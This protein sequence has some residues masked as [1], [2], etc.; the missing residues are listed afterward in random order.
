M[1]AAGEASR[2]AES[3]KR[4]GATGRE[5]ALAVA[6]R[7]PR[8]S[9]LFWWLFDNHDELLEAKGMGGLGF[10]WKAMCPVFAE[11]ELTLLA[12]A[13]VTP[14]RARQTWW[15]VR[16]EKAG[17]DGLKRRRKPNAPSG[18]RRIRDATCRRECRAGT[19]RRSPRFSRGERSVSGRRNPSPMS[20]RLS[21]KRG[22]TFPSIRR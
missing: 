8:R 15:R 20:R 7:S 11:L 21:A 19:K 6:G 17:Y 1:S 22:R 2:R 12:G 18:A 4:S 10:A 3:G 13:P 9:S 14:E 16:K 5:A